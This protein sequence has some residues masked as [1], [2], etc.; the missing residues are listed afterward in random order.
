MWCKRGVVIAFIGV[1]T[2]GVGCG[3]DDE[4]AF[5][6]GSDTLIPSPSEISTLDAAVV[7]LEGSP[8]T[9]FEP[10]PT[11]SAFDEEPTFPADLPTT[12][13]VEEPP[14]LATIPRTS[15]PGELTTPATTQFGEQPPPPVSVPGDVPAS[16]TTAFVEEP[17][18][19]TT[20][21]FPQTPTPSTE[22]L[23]EPPP[24]ATSVLE[25]QPS[26]PLCDDYT[27]NDQYPLAL[28]D[29]G[30]AVRIAQEA[31]RL[32]VDPNLVAD[33]Y[34]GPDT[35]T[36]VQLF[37]LQNGLEAD[38][39]IGPDT[40]A[41]LTPGQPGSDADGNGTI[42]PWEVPTPDP[43][44][45]LHLTGAGRSRRRGAEEPAAVVRRLGRCLTVALV[46]VARVQQVR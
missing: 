22:F 26:A 21:V 12:E 4:E 35:E 42:D 28:C 39:L 45:W 14:P 3:G 18:P 11:S 16:P 33:G 13:F 5:E 38:G 17:P 34:F 41:A 8:T 31:L 7:T 40:W 6:V 9:G 44:S 32:S 1:L 30:P 19:P 25:G 24:P 37:Q 46:V 20:V 15:V 23:E 36:A 2:G 43:A 27:F 29:E 10:P